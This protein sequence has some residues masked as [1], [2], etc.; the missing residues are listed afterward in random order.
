ML[1]RANSRKFRAAPRIPPVRRVQMW[2]Q[3][4]KA[5]YHYVRDILEFLNPIVKEEEWEERKLCNF[6]HLS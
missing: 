3:H 1:L 5:P 6:S 4:N 2:I